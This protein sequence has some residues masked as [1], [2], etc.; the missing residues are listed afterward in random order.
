LS[1]LAGQMA[2]TGGYITF[3][4]DDGHPDDMRAAELLAKYDLA[5]TFYIPATNPERR[6]MDAE[7]IR[8]IAGASSAFEMGSHTYGHQPL[9]RLSYDAAYREVIEGK[10]WLEQVTSASVV[11]FCYPKGKFNSTAVR[12]VRDVGF[13]GARTC[14]YQ[15]NGFSKDPMLWGLSTQ[16][17]SH[18]RYIQV[19]HACLERNFRGLWNYFTVHRGAVDWVEHFGKATDCVER[20]GGVAHLYFHSWEIS[21]AG[22]W[23][24]LERLF[25]EISRRPTLKRV[26]NGEV[27]RIGREKRALH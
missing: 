21:E 8:T 16:A 1:E 26:T 27:F 3:S 11:S 19:R 25:D 23:Q 2:E 6:L 18:S 15:L 20:F 17:H 5:A 4:V 24:R 10:D 7:S 12:A 22:E 14:M 13:V 9:H